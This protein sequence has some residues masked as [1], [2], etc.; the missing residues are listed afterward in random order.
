MSAQLTRVRG[1]NNT[2]ILRDE[3]GYY[4][5]LYFQVAPGYA[6]KFYLELFLVATYAFGELILLKWIIA[7]PALLY[8]KWT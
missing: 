4:G 1:F 8:C 5:K 7:N 2:H 6:A 3:V